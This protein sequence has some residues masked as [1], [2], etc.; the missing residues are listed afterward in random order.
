[1]CWDKG[2]FL[3]AEQ[4]VLRCFIF[5][6]AFLLS[7]VFRSLRFLGVYP[8]LLLKKLHIEQAILE[9]S[10]M[11]YGQFHEREFLSSDLLAEWCFESCGNCLRRRWVQWE[12]LQLIINH[13]MTTCFCDFLLFFLWDKLA[14]KHLIFVH[15]RCSKHSPTSLKILVFSLNWLFNWLTATDLK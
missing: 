6:P 7:H 5:F 9:A 14:D 11:L 3:D 10:F 15:R 4:R 2:S 1:M 13:E 12:I 8:R